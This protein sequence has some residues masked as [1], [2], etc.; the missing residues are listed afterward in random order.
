MF[1]MRKIYKKTVYKKQFTIIVTANV[2]YIHIDH[3]PV[4]LIVQSPFKIFKWPNLS[5]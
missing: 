1:A 5:L 4:H 2:E 3:S